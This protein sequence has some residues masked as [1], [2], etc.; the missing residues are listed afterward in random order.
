MEIKPIKLSPKK[1][2]YGNISSYTVNIGATEARE[3]GFI[4]SDGNILPTEKVID[5]A[6]NQIIIKLKED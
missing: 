6:N 5:T 2:G 4:D 1:N 3:C